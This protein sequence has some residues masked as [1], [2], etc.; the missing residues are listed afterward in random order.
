[1]QVHC[2]EG[3]A[4]RIGPE[5]CVLFRERLGEASVGER[6][7]WVLS[8]ES[9]IPGVD[10]VSPGGRPHDPQRDREPRVDPAR[11]ETPRMYGSFLDGNREISRLTTAAWPTWP[12]LGRRRAVANDARAGEVGQA[13]STCE[14][15][16]QRR[17]G[18]AA[19]G[20]EGS[21]LVK[22]NAEGEH[23]PRTLRRK[24]RV[25]RPHLAVPWD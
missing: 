20:V 21:C 8:R 4:I 25:K 18:S 15:P 9:T 22:G 24:L 2:D 7:G 3:V 14:A 6:A 11:S 10:P 12:A 17:G 13:G 23:T 16:E 1:M 19:E 5:P